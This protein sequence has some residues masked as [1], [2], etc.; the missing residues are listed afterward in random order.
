MQPENNLPQSGLP[1]VDQGVQRSVEQPAGSGGQRGGRNG[2]RRTPDREI[3]IF[4]G[5]V[6]RMTGDDPSSTELLNRWLDGDAPES[7]ML[8]TRDG[9]DAVDL[10]NKIHDEAE[11]LRNRT[12]PLYVHKRIMDSLPNDLYQKRLP[13]YRRPISLNP[14]LLVLLAAALVVIGVVVA[15]MLM[16]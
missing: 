7:A 1:P 16:Q 5:G 12:T 10:W 13:W 2:R 14:L 9:D 8:A 3:P 6:D 11:L 4:P 15:R